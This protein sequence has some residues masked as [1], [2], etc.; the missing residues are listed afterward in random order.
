MAQKK[1]YFDIVSLILEAE[2]DRRVA[3]A[4]NLARLEQEAKKMFK[5]YD[6]GSSL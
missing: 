6:A 4:R 2:T 3:K 1:R 5:K